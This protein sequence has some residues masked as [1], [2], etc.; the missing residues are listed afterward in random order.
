MKPDD[1]DV[2]QVV[3]DTSSTFELTDFV[4]EIE[5][6]PLDNQITIFNAI[7]RKAVFY[8]ERFY[9]LPYNDIEVS[10]FD[11]KGKFLGR[12]GKVGKGPGELLRT[13]DFLIDPPSAIS[14]LD[15][16]GKILI[17]D[18]ETFDHMKTIQLPGEL[19]AVNSF[20]KV[21]N[22]DF[23]L[24][25]I[26]HIEKHLSFY[27]KS[28]G[29]ISSKFVPN[30]D[31]RNQTFLAQI[32]PFQQTPRQGLFFNYVDKSIYVIY[33]NE[34]TLKHSF[35]FGAPGI[36][37]PSDLSNSDNKFDAFKHFLLKENKIYIADFLDL[38]HMT[39]FLISYQGLIRTLVYSKTS[40]KSG[41][42]PYKRDIYDPRDFVYLA[43]K[44]YNWIGCAVSKEAVLNNIPR[45]LLSRRSKDLIAGLDE[46]HNPI[47]IRYH[48]KEE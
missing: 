21:A 10:V 44:D 3:L 32:N 26:S 41:F 1:S 13:E 27:S 45:D 42:L 22:G 29:A 38:D 48:L 30:I 23:L 4:H 46:G 24:Y 8:Q 7:P 35:D 11:R 37:D 25:T 17:Y 33:P 28:A 20:T 19:V 5:V 47:L 39:V 15:P 16:Y 12:V 34:L 14:L 2:I 9:V 40:G 31:P 18:I 36:I 43:G 6:I